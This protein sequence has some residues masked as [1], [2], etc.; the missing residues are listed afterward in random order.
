VVLNI[1]T[2]KMLPRRGR[3]SGKEKKRRQQPLYISAR[4]QTTTATIAKDKY[5]KLHPELNPKKRKKDVEKKNLLGKDSSN[6]LERNSDVDEKIGCTS[7][8]KEV[9]L[10]SLHHKGEEKMTKLFH[11]KMQVKKTKVD[12]L[13]DFDSQANL[14]ANDLFNKLGLEVHDQLSPYPLGWVNKDAK[15]KVTK[16]CKIKFVISVDFIDEVELD[17]VPLDVCD[18]VFG[19]PYMYIRDVIFMWRAN[20]YRLIKDGKSYIINTHKGKSKI[21]MVSANQD[22]KLISSSK[23]YIFLFLRENHPREESVRVK[24]SLERCTK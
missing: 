24:K 11:I 18:V 14:I 13:F 16:Q 5:W 23:K 8:Q 21:S 1:K 10:S 22:K 20:Q 19:T 9:N 7:M 2:A 3:R 17:V 12:A 4:I 15:I 6:Q